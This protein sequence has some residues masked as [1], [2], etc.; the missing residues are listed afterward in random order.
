MLCD[1]IREVISP[2]KCTTLDDL[3]SRARVR[4]ADLLRKK[5]KEAKETK[6][7]LEF[8]DRDTKKP[9]PRLLCTH[10]RTSGART[11]QDMDDIDLLWER[12]ATLTIAR[13]VKMYE[14]KA[15]RETVQ[16]LDCHN[17]SRGGDDIHRR[18]Q[19]RG[20]VRGASG[21][22]RERTQ[23]FRSTRILIRYY[24][25][26]SS[27]ERLARSQRLCGRVEY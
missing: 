22:V 15:H 18:S 17:D 26:N 25:K 11:Q 8:R 23:L 19:L 9:N 14:T 4:Q 1:D 21:S 2:F 16:V 5:N 27:V 3:L 24:T 12:S 6:R 20:S 7:K 10:S 13:I